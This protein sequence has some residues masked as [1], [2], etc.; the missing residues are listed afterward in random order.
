MVDYVLTT[1]V[2]DLLGSLLAVEDMIK[3]VDSMLES[4]LDLYFILADVLDLLW[5]FH[6]IELR[7]ELYKDLLRRSVTLSLFGWWTV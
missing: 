5:S 7:F 6:L 2:E 3:F 1:N 4:S